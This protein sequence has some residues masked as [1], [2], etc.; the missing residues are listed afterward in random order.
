MPF[1]K[2]KCSAFF[3]ATV[4]V[5][6]LSLFKKFSPSQR[7]GIWQRAFRSKYWNVLE[8]KLAVLLVKELCHICV[9][10]IL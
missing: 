7:K 9:V 4:L 5:L 2:K 10:K 3:T 8:Q 6:V 1:F